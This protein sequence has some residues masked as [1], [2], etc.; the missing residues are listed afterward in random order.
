MEGIVAHNLQDIMFP[1]A[2]F[3]EAERNKQLADFDKQKEIVRQIYEHGVNDLLTVMGVGSLKFVLS[4]DDR[5][6]LIALENYQY[7]ALFNL[8]WLLGE[9][10]L[11]GKKLDL[12]YLYE[13]CCPL[14]EMSVP[15]KAKFSVTI[16][17]GLYGLPVSKKA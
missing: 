14:Q 9:V 2:V 13:E 17:G 16:N 10:S 3:T 15:K 4:A 6:K 12:S 8:W 11:A 7:S 5:E 1:K